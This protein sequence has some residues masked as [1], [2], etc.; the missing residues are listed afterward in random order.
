MST[1]VAIA[2]ETAR[3]DAG[4]IELKPEQIIDLP[5]EQEVG[6]EARLGVAR[7]HTMSHDQLREV[8][9]D[10]IEMLDGVLKERKSRAAAIEEAMLA[11]RVLEIRRQRARRI[12]RKVNIGSS[13]IAA[14]F[15][16]VVVAGM[17]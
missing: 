14:M 10:R 17:F 12:R 15:T 1:A 4:I 7:L 3:P 11:Q 13:L 9:D 5:S 8:I 2:A 16:G 6:E